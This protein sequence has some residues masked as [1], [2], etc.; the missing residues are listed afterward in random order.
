M[1]LKLKNAHATNAMQNIVSIILAMTPSPCVG[2]VWTGIFVRV[3]VACV[4]SAG[5]VKNKVSFV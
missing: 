2:A 5:G 1:V 4:R 3:R